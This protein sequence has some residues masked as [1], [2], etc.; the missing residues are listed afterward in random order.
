MKLSDVTVCSFCPSFYECVR[1]VIHNSNVKRFT[2]VSS[3]EWIVV[4][5]QTIFRSVLLHCSVMDALCHSHEIIL[6]IFM[7]CIPFCFVQMFNK[8]TKHT[9]NLSCDKIFPGCCSIWMCLLSKVW[10]ISRAFSE[11]GHRLLGSHF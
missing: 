7:H 4:Y 3:S 10:H 9:V 11:L 2:L 8:T 1:H 5:S 6:H